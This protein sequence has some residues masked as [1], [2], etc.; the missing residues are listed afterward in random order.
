MRVGRKAARQGGTV[1]SSGGMFQDLNMVG[2]STGR[3]Q[4][5][6]EILG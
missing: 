6:A 5:V 1:A 3:V 2:E 4:G